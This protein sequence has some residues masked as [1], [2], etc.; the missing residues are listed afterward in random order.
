MNQTQSQCNSINFALKGL[1]LRCIPLSIGQKLKYEKII[2]LKSTHRNTL[3]I[4]LNTNNCAHLPSSSN[5][6]A[7]VK[8]FSILAN[9]FSSVAVVS[10]LH[11]LWTESENIK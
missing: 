1:D 2:K 6:S 8:S 7:E 4:I 5:T 10:S 9:V 3:A 11:T